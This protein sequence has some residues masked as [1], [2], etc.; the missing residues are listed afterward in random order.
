MSD[1]ERERL[2]AAI[3]RSFEQVAAGKTVPYE[4]VMAELRALPL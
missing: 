1:E 2:Y 3:N 4:Q